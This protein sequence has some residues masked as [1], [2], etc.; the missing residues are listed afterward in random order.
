MEGK[1]HV[2]GG[3]LAHRIRNSMND[4]IPE[5]TKAKM[6]GDA[7]K[8]GSAAGVKDKKSA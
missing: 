8:P 3:S 1:N 7:A 2:L 5:Q 4:F 6:Y